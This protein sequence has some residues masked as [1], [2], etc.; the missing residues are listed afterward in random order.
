MLVAGSLEKW[1]RKHHGPRVQA[2]AISFISKKVDEMEAFG[3]GNDYCLKVVINECINKYTPDV[4]FSTLTRWWKT[5]LEWG[6]LHW[7]VKERRKE[8]RQKMKTMGTGAM[9]NDDEL[10]QLKYI[11]DDNPQLYLDEISLHFA[12]KTGKYLCDST[13]WT[14]MTNKL[15]YSLKVLSDVAKQRSK[16]E[17]IAFMNCLEC[18]LQECPDRLIIVD[19]THKDRNASRRRRG[20]AKRNTDAETNQWY[21]EC[22]RYTMLGVADINGFIV[23]A[24]ETVRRDEISNEGAAGTVDSKYFLWWVKNRLVPVLGNYE[25]GEPRS[26]VFMDNAST[27]MTEEVEYAINQAGA[28]LIYGAP[29]SPHL[30]PI[31]NY[32]SLYKKYLKR[33]NSRM[34]DDWENVHFEALL[35]V[36]R[37]IGIKYIRRCGIP[38]SQLM[39]TEDEYSQLER[40]YYDEIEYIN[41]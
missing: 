28:L 39:L 4:S 38:G 14:Y 34:H 26:V 15:G 41:E 2:A 10:L 27:H 32:F 37:D 16:D 30:N 5:Y 31:E 13:I 23:S 17:E 22:V 21:R 24:C 8:M 11:I 20:Y 7:V 35:T 1:A 25:L 19:E 29:Y 33:N 36:D 18:M 12:I 3:G 40:Q 9:I 6:E